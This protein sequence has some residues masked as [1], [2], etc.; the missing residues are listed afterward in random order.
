MGRPGRITVIKQSR[1]KLAK[2]ISILGTR[3]DLE[4]INRL[5]NHFQLM[6]IKHPSESMDKFIVVSSTKYCKVCEC[7]KR[8]VRKRAAVKRPLEELSVNSTVQAGS[9]TDQ[10]RRDWYPR[11]RYGRILFGIHPCRNWKCWKEHVDAIR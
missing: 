7:A 4:L 5:P 1:T 8:P 10:K 3:S 2:L 11:S 9:S 6:Y